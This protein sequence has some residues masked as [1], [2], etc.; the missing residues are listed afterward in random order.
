[1]SFEN[2]P[3]IEQ[4]QDGLPP[5]LPDALKR[6]RIIRILI[7]ILFIAVLGLGAFNFL[8]SDTAS[9]LM[10]TGS[11]SGS[12]VNSEGKPIPAEIMILGT[13]IHGSAG[14]D[15]T[16]LLE[17][18]PEG[19]QVLVAGYE[20]KGVEQQIVVSSGQM[21]ELKTIQIIST[22]VPSSN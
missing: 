9:I 7:S 4:F 8:K 14:D 16:F 2:S 17:K 10:K 13:N 20:G 3:S 5:K 12:V 19:Q 18:I 6:R 15:G 1:M 22:A 11:L 21:Q